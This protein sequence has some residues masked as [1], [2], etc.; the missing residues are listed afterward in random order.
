VLTIGVQ[1]DNPAQPIII[2]WLALM[3]FVGLAAFAIGLI[4]HA[5]RKIKLNSHASKAIL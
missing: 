2:A 3:L 1:L 4:R 5:R